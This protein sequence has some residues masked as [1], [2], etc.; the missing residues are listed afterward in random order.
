MAKRNAN[1]TTKKHDELFRKLQDLAIQETP[2]RFTEFQ[3]F[4]D[5]FVMENT[6]ISTADYKTSSF[7]VLLPLQSGENGSMSYDLDWLED[8]MFEMYKGIGLI[9]AYGK[10][11]NARM[12]SVWFIIEIL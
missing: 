10:F 1:G 11:G 3:Y 9:I 8:N 4:T 6:K 12:R 2:I 5:G 7:E